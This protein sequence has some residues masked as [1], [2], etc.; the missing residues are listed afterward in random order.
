VIYAAMQRADEPDGP[1]SAGSDG[2]TVP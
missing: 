2:A 1:R